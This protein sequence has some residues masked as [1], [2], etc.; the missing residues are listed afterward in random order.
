MATFTV[1]TIEDIVDADDN[2]L[3]LRE[4]V[5]AA[6]ASAAA[7]A[8]QF[9]DT[10]SNDGPA[11]VV[12]EDGAL[13]IEASGALTVNG[14]SNDDGVAD[15]V[16]NAGLHH[17][18]TVGSGADLTLIGLDLIGG[19]PEQN[20]GGS[21]SGGAGGRGEDFGI[22]FGFRAETAEASGD[23]RF[24]EN[25][26]GVSGDDGRQGGEGGTGADGADAPA[27][28]AAID[29]FGDLDLL[30]VGFGANLGLGPNGGNG[31]RG[32][33]GGRGEQ[34]GD[35]FRGNF[36][37]L[38]DGELS[39][40][41]NGLGN[42]VLE[43]GDGGDGGDGGT[44]GKGGD[45]GTG[46]DVAGAILNRPGGSVDLTD[47][48]FGGGLVSGLVFG[49]NTGLGGVGG[50]PGG[51]GF[52]GGGGT[53]G[54]GALG[55]ARNI[56]TTVIVD[57]E[58]EV[59]RSA[60]VGLPGD[61]GDAGA[62]GRGGDGGA[63][64]DAGSA[65][66]GIL[67]FGVVSGDAAFFGNSGT[68]GAARPDDPDDLNF[69]GALPGTSGGPGDL[70]GVSGTGFTA[71]SILTPPGEPGNEAPA[72]GPGNNFT[73]GAGGEAANDI[74]NKGAGG[75]TAS[76]G[77]ILVFAHGVD[78]VTQDA[79]DAPGLRFNLIRVGATSG[80][81]TVNW[82]VR[83]A[84]GSTLSGADFPGGELPS[85]SAV[86]EGLPPSGGPH[87]TA[88]E[89]VEIS[90]ARDGIAEA[91]EGLQFVVTSAILDTGAPVQ[92]GTAAIAGVLEASETTPDTEHPDPERPVPETPDP[93]TP[94]PDAEEPGEP[95]TPPAPDEGTSG[96]DLFEGDD[97]SDAFEGG[98]GNDTLNGGG[99][100]DSL[101]GGGGRDE[102]IGGRGQDDLSGNGGRD[103]LQ[104]G[105]GKDNLSGNGGR[106]TLEGGGGRDTLDGGG[107][108]DL[109]Q[110][111]GGRD[112]LDGGGGK[113]IMQ[114]GNGRDDI[115]GGRGS[116]TLTGEGGSDRFIFDRG[117]GRDT[118][119]DFQQGRDK[120]VIEGGAEEFGDLR[121]T[122][123]GDDVRIFIANTRVTVEDDLVENFSAA[124]FIF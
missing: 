16:L 87:V 27:Q 82:E 69:G 3:S 81:V 31:G 95:L 112:M 39:P 65:A 32:G 18:I 107:G 48:V 40:F 64:G 24:E 123:F 35:G 8:I 25:N 6:N 119:T 58:R 62:G 4:A 28:A 85:G 106:D 113:D 89:I 114:G 59:I 77:S 53:G 61:G 5:A 117:N 116:D 20:G 108:R 21:A 9:S 98:G 15:I 38:L 2:L 105:G 67:N 104:G 121:I 13:L 34:G 1:T 7:D 66:G 124:D 49:G 94:D 122:Q 70:G 43:G 50:Q 83:A 14:D 17:H 60:T 86:L 22:A 46:G 41:N 37:V 102:L 23:P 11:V 36:F 92:I 74:L 51:G 103:L 76:L 26:G 109:L 44:G 73:A 99:G 71:P 79:E 111:G 100:N 78:T 84:D 91:A 55:G 45:G 19:Q 115:F 96:A 118:I 10:L 63:F 72:L 47:A 29:N 97:A 88:S 54:D 90:I 30:R 80:D 101:S 56:G 68:A 120:I 12:I 52:G 33:D 57:G 42:G 110:G 93:E 75:S